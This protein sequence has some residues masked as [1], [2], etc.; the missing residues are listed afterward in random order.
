[1]T[2]EDPEAALATR[3]RDLAE[4][5]EDG[6]LLHYFLATAI[7]E[8]QDI[9]AEVGVVNPPRRDP[10]MLAS[11]DFVSLVFGQSADALA[12]MNCHPPRGA[13]IAMEVLK[14]GLQLAVHL[15]APTPHG[16]AD[17]VRHVERTA[18]LA[19]ELG[20]TIARLSYEKSGVLENAE[21]RLKTAQINAESL[22]AGRA[23]TQEKAAAWRAAASLVIREI[24]RGT[25]PQKQEALVTAAMT[26]LATADL[27]RGRTTVS[28]LVADL[29]RAGEI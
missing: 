11:A 29:K 21:R 24:A 19:M 10:E 12:G 17:P 15:E 18:M 16:A 3:L 7:D 13:G 27:G 23:V 26:R 8:A 25:G 9:L 1:M 22:H 20:S 2:P 14:A 6:V 4:D 28:N 5:G